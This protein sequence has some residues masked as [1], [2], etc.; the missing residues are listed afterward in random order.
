VRVAVC[1]AVRVAVCVAVCVAV[2]V[3]VYVAICVEVC[4]AVCVAVC[5][6]VCVWLRRATHQK[7]PT[8]VHQNTL[9]EHR[10]NTPRALYKQ[11]VDGCVSSDVWGEFGQ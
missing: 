6:A 8:R 11:K 4:V 1:V 9:R 7:N 10:N 2:R 3:A 5:I